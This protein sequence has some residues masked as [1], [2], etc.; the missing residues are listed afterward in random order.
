MILLWGTMDDEPLE[1]TAAALTRAGA[2]HVFLDHRKIFTS[3]IEYTR[4]VKGMQRCIVTANDTAIDMSAVNVAYVRGS[5][6]NDYEEMHERPQNDPLAMRAARFEMELMAWLDASDA[7][8]INRS[9]PSAT[10]HSKPYQLAMIRQ[11]GFAIPETFITNDAAA[12]REFLSNNPD[13]VY[14]SVSGVRSVVR[15]VGEV[16]RSFIDD[17]RWCPT[18]F[19]RFVPGNNYR[20]HVVGSEVLAVRIE[21]DQ[22]DYRYGRTSMIATTLPVEVEQRCQ[23]LTA[24]LGLYFSGIDLMR[25]PQGEWFCFEVNPSPGYPYFE[26]LGGQAIDAALARFMM[27]ADAERSAHRLGDSS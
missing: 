4:D 16:Q 10:N 18:L 7:V 17:V 23:Q 20:V 11:A 5:D 14:K 27:E 21:S 22:L 1:M 26:M 12:A 9:G 13:S 25:T 2:E 3:E 24:M 6:F 8:V 15:R 19:Q